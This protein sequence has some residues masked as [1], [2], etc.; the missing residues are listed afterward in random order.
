MG[1]RES[2]IEVYYVKETAAILKTSRQQ[3]RKMIQSEELQAVKVGRE[4]RITSDALQEFL[5]QGE[6]T[7]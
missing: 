1:L 7:E 2:Q 5:E 3:V 6:F 4:W